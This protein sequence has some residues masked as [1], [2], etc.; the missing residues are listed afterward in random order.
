[1][2][3]YPDNIKLRKGGEMTDVMTSILT[4]ANARSDASVERA[5]ISNAKVISPWKNLV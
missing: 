1:M 3:N 2:F 5:F 4:D